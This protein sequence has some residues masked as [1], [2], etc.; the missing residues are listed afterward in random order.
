MGGEIWVE[1]ELGRGSGF[2]FRIIM[3][4]ATG[5]LEQPHRAPDWMRRALLIDL[6]GVT[7]SITERQ[8]QAL[9]LEV[10]TIDAW[11][12]GCLAFTD[13]VFVGAGMVQSA[14]LASDL[15]T[16]GESGPATFV[17]TG[18]TAMR[19]AV[20]FAVTAA[21]P[22]PVMRRDLAAALSQ[23]TRPPVPEPDR[24][25]AIAAAA[26]P[27]FAHPS[28]DASETHAL[29]AFMGGK[30]TESAEEV[31]S[32]AEMDRGVLLVSAPRRMRVLLAE[33]NRTN[34]L[35]FSSMVK[36]MAIDLEIV[37]NGL[38]AVD[39]FR[40]RRPDLIFT[41]ISMPLMDG[42]DAARRIR[43]IEAETGAPRTPIVAITAHAM[44]HHAREILA[45]G[46]DY[47]LTKPLKKAAL[48]EYILAACPDD[49]VAPI[50]GSATATEQAAAAAVGATIGNDF[51]GIG[52]TSSAA[53]LP[54]VEGSKLA[55]A[56]ASS[57]SL[58]WV[59]GHSDG[60]GG[61]SDEG[62]AT[63][64]AVLGHLMPSA[65]VLRGKDSDDAA[66]A[67]AG[68]SAD[69]M[70]PETTW[71]EEHGSPTGAALRGKHTHDRPFSDIF[72]E[73]AN[74]QMRSEADAVQPSGA[75]SSPLLLSDPVTSAPVL[76]RRRYDASLSASSAP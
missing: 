65:P 17:L 64:E 56:S 53:N 43:A 55:D 30:V 5:T 62:K 8:L 59:A 27:A 29:P 48:E 58:R 16:A 9:G 6:P 13:A 3:P 54:A 51:A 47:Y 23:A 44:E 26:L 38:E 73:R 21:L 37:G 18:S 67:S 66:V 28:V 31:P 75:P 4:A 15:A 35:V 46:V 34:Q 72:H 36:S 33:D 14:G 45:T 76:F 42:K 50:A 60:G 39:A 57:P 40:R 49:A 25:S 2:G 70:T 1:S 22:R 19:P 32:P 20:P 68:T 41:D 12:P 74:G 11:A 71:A 61:E 7:R 52:E 69:A 10:R 24:S 63:G